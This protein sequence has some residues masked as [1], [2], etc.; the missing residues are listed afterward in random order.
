MFVDKYEINNDL[1]QHSDFKKLMAARFLHATKVLIEKVNRAKF[2]TAGL[3]KN[4]IRLS[5][6]SSN[7]ETCGWVM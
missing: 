6:P 3:W 7:P 2:C 5:P 4:A 1:L